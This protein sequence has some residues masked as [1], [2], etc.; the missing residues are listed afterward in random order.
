MRLLIRIFPLVI[1]LGLAIPG[2]TTNAFAQKNSIRYS[3][4][5]KDTRKEQKRLRKE[6]KLNEKRRAKQFKD[7]GL[8]ADKKSQRAARKAN[9]KKDKT[10]SYLDR[11]L[12]DKKEVSPG[13]K[14][15]AYRRD[16]QISRAN[17]Q[18]KSKMTRNR[19]KKRKPPKRKHG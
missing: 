10:G 12:T 4:P 18:R 9:S 6:Q 5:G 3:N 19:I 13:E 7:K 15:E 2:V 14:K 8:G 11:V 17:T 16:R 1:I